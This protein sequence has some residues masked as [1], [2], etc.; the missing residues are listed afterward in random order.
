MVSLSSIVER[1]SEMEDFVFN[2]IP[3]PQ[4]FPLSIYQVVS[5]R[6]S[7]IFNKV[8]RA[9]LKSI[10]DLTPEWLR[11]FNLTNRFIW[12]FAFDVLPPPYVEINEF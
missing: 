8:L 9:S 12:S 7:T 2:Y 6:W 1:F 5:D 10:I 3:H 11:A 4:Q